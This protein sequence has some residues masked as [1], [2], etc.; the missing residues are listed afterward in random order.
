MHE[1]DGRAREEDGPIRM[2][3]GENK[4]NGIKE[5]DESLYCLSLL[6]NSHLLNLTSFCSISSHLFSF[7]F[8][9]SNHLPKISHLVSSHKRNNSLY[10]RVAYQHIN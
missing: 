6:H 10:L 2:K 4:Q 9:S 3:F 5:K 1:E 7:H 8:I